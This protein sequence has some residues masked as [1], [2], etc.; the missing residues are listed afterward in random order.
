MS[1]ELS[2]KMRGGGVVPFVLEQA[3]PFRVVEDDA[4]TTQEA[5]AVCNLAVLDLMHSGDNHHQRYVA[6]LIDEHHRRG[7]AVA[8]IDSVAELCYASGLAR[9]DI[10]ASPYLGVELGPRP[11]CDLWLAG[12]TYAPLA[13][14]LEQAA[15]LRGHI[16]FPVRRVLVTMGGS[17]P[18]ELTTQVADCYLHSELRDQ[19][20]LRIIVGPYFA[21]KQE[22]ALTA[23]AP[24][25]EIVRSPASLSEHYQWADVVVT[26]GGLTRYECAALGL[27]CLLIIPHE[28]HKDY[29]QRFADL[30]IAKV[31]HLQHNED[32]SA[33]I[34]R[35]L[36]EFLT[37]TQAL[38]DFA[39][40]GPVR[41]PPDGAIR[42]AHALAETARGRES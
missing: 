25:V 27:P 42:L 17:D 19:Y 41:V 24:N 22:A 7:R 21:A 11:R 16:Q 34:T 36:S 23:H 15:T 3:I 20:R 6:S 37:D 35:A 9:P 26:T 4:T 14:W 38:R 32:R 39:R 31:L 5:E 2:I 13:P 28:L 40:N 10:V 1:A 8:L 29:F 12:A 30:R 33:V 18:A